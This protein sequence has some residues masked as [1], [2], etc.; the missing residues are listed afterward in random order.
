MSSQFV[1]LAGVFG[2]LGVA[3]GAFGAHA[4]KARLAADALQTWTLGSRYVMVHA[5]VLLG[6]AILSEL[7]PST[8]L[9]ISGWCFV[10]G[11][12]IFGG[13]LWT[14]SFTGIKWLGAITPI[15]G[16]ALLVG[17]A[18]LAWAGFT[19]RSVL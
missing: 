11:M 18:L 9:T 3:T 8:A 17:W 19:G 4:L 10:V 14:L 7:R 12:C 13:T 15:G 2:F 6:V 5:A 1:A 16:T